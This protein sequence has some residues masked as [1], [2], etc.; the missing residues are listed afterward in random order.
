MLGLRSGRL[1]KPRGFAYVPRHYD[2]DAD[3]RRKRRL[4]FSRPSEKRTRKTK[5]PA[6]IAVGLG[7]VL[8]LYIYANLEMFIERAAAFGAFF[9]GG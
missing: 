4:R 8:A 7:L 1:A 3:E 2:A 6:F 9:F 5:Q